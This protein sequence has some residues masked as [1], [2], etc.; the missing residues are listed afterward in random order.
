MCNDVHKKKKLFKLLFLENEGMYV[1]CDAYV[2]THTK[3]KEKALASEEKNMITK[4]SN[5]KKG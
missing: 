5:E 3:K 2:W 1:L 4:K